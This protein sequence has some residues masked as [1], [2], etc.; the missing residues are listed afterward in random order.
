ML[1]AKKIGASIGPDGRKY[2]AQCARG[3]TR[4]TRKAIEQPPE[5]KEAV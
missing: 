2:I 4:R 1:C 3:Y 5:R